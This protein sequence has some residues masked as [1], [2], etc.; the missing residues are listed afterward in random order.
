MADPGGT[1]P[2]SQDIRN[3]EEL[4]Q[5][6]REVRDTL[7]SVGAAFKTQ[8]ADQIDDLVEAER[9]A[10][11]I[12]SKDFVAGLNAAAKITRQSEITQ[13]KINGSL[14][15]Q[16]SIERQI[17]TIKTTQLSLANDLAQLQLQ[18]IQLTL[19]QTE[20][21]NDAT[22]A[23]EVQL[24]ILNKQLATSKRLSEETKEFHELLMGM[25]KIPIIGPLLG[26][27]KVL[28]KVKEAADKGKSGVQQMVVGFDQ[29]FKNI[30]SGLLL[31]GIAKI[32][33]FVVESVVQFDKKAFD[34]A[35][36]L[37]ITVG[38]AKK[39]QSVFQDVAISSKNIALLGKDVAETFGQMTESLGFMGPQNREF[40]ESTALI[41][42]RLGLSAESMNALATQSALSGKSFMA[43]YKTVQATRLEEGAKNKLMLSAKQI[44]D[45]IAKTSKAVLINFKGSDSALGAA[46]IRAT[47]LGTTLDT[48]NKQGESLLDFESSIAKEFEAQLLTGKNIN[49]T[50]ARELA[51][52]GDTR[53]LME[54]LNKQNVK[55]ADY[56]KMNVI[57]R[58]AFAEAIGLSTEEL[59][60]QLIEQD[61]AK[62]LGA[63]QGVSAQ[64]QYKKLLGEKKTRE[65]IAE[66]VGKDAE[67]DL[68]K[69]SKAEAFQA[70]IERLKDTIGEMLQGPVGGL[71][72]KFT[73]FVNDGEKM[74]MIGE[75]LK[76]IFNFIG[77]TIER[78]PQILS[79]AVQISKVLATI[80]IARAVASI[81]GSLGFIPVVGAGLGIAAGYKTYSWLD[82]LLS[83]GGGSPPSATT[84]AQPPPSE[85]VLKPMNS[86]AAMASQASNSSENE[87]KRQPIFNLQN[88]TIVGT[89]K[90]DSQTRSSLSESPGTWAQ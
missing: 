27:S 80:S 17:D 79:S 14:K 73:E 58:K 36:N 50:K 38:E 22:A 34:I 23:L 15:Q 61:K 76:E 42:K 49:L 64:E 32:L 77:K 31:G 68:N 84:A 5:V 16:A 70:T 52:M 48:I 2:S 88:T 62:K 66:L 6:L 35:K 65:E 85:D 60:K 37:G 75:K 18:G 29:A 89:E 55:L 28:E 56:E 72:T 86:N 39:L 83:G 81:A 19:D 57:A 9:V 43:V 24:G 45:G 1:G 20:K 10:A 87:K 3:A 51:L 46:I 21:Y 7:I 69:A 67:A 8:L 41:Q 11:K 44:I 25:S 54:E 90:W 4:N 63:E 33:T 82:G 40:L 71:I 30:G 13:T 26:M 47:K 12:I 74:K 53:G 59:S 78:F